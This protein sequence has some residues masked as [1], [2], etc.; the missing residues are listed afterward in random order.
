M[1]K[2]R[3]LAEVQADLLLSAV[4]D[5]GEAVSGDHLQPLCGS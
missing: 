2:P 4:G 1:Q 3:D 5:L